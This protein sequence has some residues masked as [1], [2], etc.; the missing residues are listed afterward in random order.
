MP[1]QT[2]GTPLKGGCMMIKFMNPFVS[3]DKSEYYQY[4]VAH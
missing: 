3:V 4:Y 2:Y 1:E